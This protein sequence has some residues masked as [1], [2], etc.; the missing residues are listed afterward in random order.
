MV[1]V[2]GA[3][4]E[5]PA[6]AEFLHPGQGIIIVFPLATAPVIFELG[7]VNR[8]KHA[9]FIAMKILVLVEF[10]IEGE[11][12]FPAEDPLHDNMVGVFVA[13][14]VSSLMPPRMPVEVPS[15][16]IDIFRPSAV[17]CCMNRHNTSAFPDILNETL[18]HLRTGQAAFDA[19]GVVQVDRIIVAEVFQT[20]VLGILGE[21]GFKEPGFLS[22]ASGHFL[23]HSDGGMFVG[24]SL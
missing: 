13:D 19:G 21:I 20:Q 17:R 8:Q 15:D 9:H 16:H 24:V 3:G 11:I 23:G 18:A 1:V 22:H 4:N 10:V 12:S 14:A 7:H 2:S 6:L 5:Y